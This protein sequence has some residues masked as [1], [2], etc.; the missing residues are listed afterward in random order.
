MTPRSLLT[1]LRALIDTAAIRDAFDAMS[2]PG[3]L[4]SRGAPGVT[5]LAL[6]P[7]AAPATA[8]PWLHASFA[9]ACLS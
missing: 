9:D 3:A 7:D 1:S 8:R 6:N 5:D 4:N 2:S